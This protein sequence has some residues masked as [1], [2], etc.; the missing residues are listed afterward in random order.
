VERHALRSAADAGG[1]GVANARE[2]ICPEV[3]DRRGSAIRETDED[4]LDA[5]LCLRGVA[6]KAR[7]NMRLAHASYAAARASAVKAW[8]CAGILCMGERST[9]G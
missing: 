8:E 3:V 4:L 5:F 2:E 1:G 9:S 6:Q 7:A